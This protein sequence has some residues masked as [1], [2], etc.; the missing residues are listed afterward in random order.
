M[1]NINTT[2]ELQRRLRVLTIRGAISAADIEQC[3]QAGHLE[4][5]ILTIWDFASGSLRFDPD[6]AGGLSIR[7]AAVSGP[8]QTRHPVRTAL[9]CPNELDHGLL[10]ILRVFARTLHYPEQIRLFRNKRAARRWIGACAICMELT[11]TGAAQP[12]SCKQ[13]C[14]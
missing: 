6:E 5:S 12:A 9:F 7:P 11:R 1:A 14:P 2:H 8:R 10:R 3:L 13:I 4:S